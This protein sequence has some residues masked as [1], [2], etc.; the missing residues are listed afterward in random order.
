M[1]PREGRKQTHM[2]PMLRKSLTL[3]WKPH[4]AHR[5]SGADL[6]LLPP[7][8]W[9]CRSFDHVD[10]E[11]LAFL[12]SSIPLAHSIPSSMRLPEP[13]GEG[14]DGDIPFRAQCSQTSHRLHNDEDSHVGTSSTN[15]LYRCLHQW[16]LAISLWRTACR[17]GNSLGCLGVTMG[18]LCP[19]VQLDVT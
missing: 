11:G 7:S 6:C 12:V 3:S 13:W 15:E 2:F 17:R 9:V 5:G 10:L 4:C 19:A 8:L 18:P 1:S 14:L 16:G